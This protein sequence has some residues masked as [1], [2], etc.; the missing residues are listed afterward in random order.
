MIAQNTN[1]SILALNNLSQG[2]YILK[3]YEKGLTLTKKIIL[4]A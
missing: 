2:V 4:G 1:K 3:I